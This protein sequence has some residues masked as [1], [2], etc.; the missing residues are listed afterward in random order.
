MKRPVDRPRTLRAWLDDGARSGE[1]TLRPIAALLDR[2]GG[3]AAFA[4]A[5]PELLVTLDL[6]ET[7]EADPE[8]LTAC[9]V[10]TL[11]SCNLAVPP[12]DAPPSAGMRNLIEGQQAA[13]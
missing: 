1:P 6:L 2:A 7:L 8:T 5:E 13:E 4:A 12:A 9:I 3:N 10:H 11:Q